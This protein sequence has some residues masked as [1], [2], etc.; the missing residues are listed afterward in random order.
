[1]NPNDIALENARRHALR[2]PLPDP[3][4]GDPSDPLRIATANGPDTFHVPRTML[5][6]PDYRP[7]LSR[8]A[9]DLLRFRHDF[10]YWAARCVTISDKHTMLETPFRLNRPQRRLLALLESQRRADQ[11][12]RIIMLKARQ[13]GGSTLVQIYFAWIQIIH[14][15]NWNSIICAHVKDTSAT[16]R[17]I[18]ARLLSSYP[19]A[20]WQ[21]DCKPEFRPF[22]RT[23]NTRLIPGRGCRVT[24]SSSEN[25]ESVRG[26]DFALA[27]LSEVAFWKDS[28]L[29]R[30]EDL[31]RSIASVI[32]RKPLSAVVMESTANGVGN[33]FHRE[34]LRASIPDQSD[35][36]PFFVPWHEIELYAEPV[37]DPQAFFDTLTPY[38][39][40][41][42]D[43]HSCTLEA[44]H[45]YRLKRREY[46]DHRAMMAEFP[47]TPTEAFASTTHNVFDTA[48]VD[49]LRAHCRPPSLT[50]EVEMGRPGTFTSPPR[51]VPSPSG[52]LSVW[53]PPAPDTRYIASL[54]IGGRTH[55]ADWSVLTVLTIPD[56]AS[57]PEV[58]AQWRGHIDHDLL[59]WRAAAIAR[60]YNTALLVVESNTWD[61]AAEGRG[62]YIFDLLAEGYPN[63][64]YRRGTDP[65]PSDTSVGRPM[66]GF[67]TNARTKPALISNLI[68]HVRDTRYIERDP[69]ACDELL[70]YEALPDGT[71][72]AR[73]GCHDDRL[74]SRAI[75]LWLIATLP[76]P[77]PIA[78]STLLTAL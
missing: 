16:I 31:V 3:I 34:W 61:S 9:F 48:D 57:P 35:K 42:W 41:L 1:M 78:P 14:R 21:E 45:W 64:Y 53:T 58:V 5:A 24:L 66:P 47:T 11:P 17:G 55:A 26:T 60:W 59:A 43:N 27:H 69:S 29:C 71:Y 36:A 7:G 70:Q 50:G 20:Y 46:Q 33:F 54:D 38:E 73:R 25:Q 32:G 40:N 13:W 62:R 39:R 30:P 52:A 44:I 10:E 63:L 15:R 76:P 8:L 12:I 77:V 4:L 68:A 74:M 49:R 56:A 19:E 18:Y 51:F 28:T 22:E 65:T 75:A 67:H 6:D 2:P 23:L 37:A 72:A